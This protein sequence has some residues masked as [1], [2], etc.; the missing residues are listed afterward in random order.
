VTGYLI[1]RVGI[2]RNTIMAAS[3]NLQAAKALAVDFLNK[4]PDRYHGMEVVYVTPVGESDTSLLVRYG[5][6]FLGGPTAGQEELI[7]FVQERYE[8]PEW[9]QTKGGK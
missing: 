4:E 3:D 7:W 9:L 6:Q 2:Y 5:Y 1:I 8:T